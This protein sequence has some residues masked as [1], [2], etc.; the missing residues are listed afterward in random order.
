MRG[1]GR[2]EICFLAGRWLDL[3]GSF[4]LAELVGKTFMVFAQIV[5][6]GTSIP[7]PNAHVSLY[8]APSVLNFSFPHGS[9]FKQVR[10]PRG[11]QVFL[12]LMGPGLGNFTPFAL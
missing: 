1:V 9:S 7:A 8:K 6:H 4:A 2:G 10:P 12:P 3:L 11:S 5:E